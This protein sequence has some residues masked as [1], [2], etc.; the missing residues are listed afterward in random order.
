VQKPG[1]WRVVVRNAA[2]K[3]L[4]QSAFEILDAAAP[5]DAK[6]AAKAADAKPG[7]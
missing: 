5:N 4:G 3:E 2:G 7:A 6:P 1:K